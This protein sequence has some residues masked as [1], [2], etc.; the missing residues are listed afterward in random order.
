MVKTSGQKLHDKLS[1]SL[2]NKSVLSH[3]AL[4]TSSICM[5][6]NSPFVF[7]VILNSD[8]IIIDRKEKAPVCISCVYIVKTRKA[9]KKLLTVLL[10]LTE[11]PVIF[12]C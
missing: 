9:Y 3:D 4:T 1:M 11:L 7:C 2:L 10:S 6:C 5:M 8:H 12:L